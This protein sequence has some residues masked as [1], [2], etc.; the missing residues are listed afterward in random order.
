MPSVLAS[1]LVGSIITIAL[2]LGAVIAVTIWYVVL[3]QKGAGE[4]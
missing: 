1:F 2:P 3:W 4:R